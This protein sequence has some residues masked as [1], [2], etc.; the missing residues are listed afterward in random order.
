MNL[1]VQS[2]KEEILNLHYSIIALMINAST[3]KI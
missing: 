2:L 3:K 1:L